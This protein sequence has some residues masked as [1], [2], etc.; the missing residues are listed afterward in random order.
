MRCTASREYGMN[1]AQIY[2]WRHPP[3]ITP[4][5]NPPELTPMGR[6]RS[7]PQ[8][9]GRIGSE[10]RVSTSFSNFGF[11]NVATLRGVTSGGIFSSLGG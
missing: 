9:V 6:L 4:R 8:L 3:Q 1:D 7:G 2:H 10:V 11:K 5:E